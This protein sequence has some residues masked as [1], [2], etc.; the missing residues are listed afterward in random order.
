MWQGVEHRHACPVSQ[1]A[2]C[3]FAADATRS[4]RDQHVTWPHG[5]GFHGATLRA[6]AR[7]CVHRAF[8]SERTA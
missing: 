1:E 2:E 8:E 4:A 6:E 5:V 7:A 3:G